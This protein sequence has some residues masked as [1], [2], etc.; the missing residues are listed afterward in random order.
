VNEALKTKL[1]TLPASPGVYFHKSAGGEVIYVGK[2]AVL[3]NRVRQYFQAARNLDAKT[4]ALVAEIDDTDWLET[5]SEIDALFLESEMVKRYMPRYNVLLRDDKSQ[6][7]VRIDMKSEWPTVSFTR[8]PQDDGADYYGPF[9]NG[10]ALKKALRYLRRVFPYFIREPK[11]TDSKLEQQIGLNP[12]M[13][14]GSDAYKATLRKL[15]SYIKGNRKAIAREIEADMKQAAREHDFETAARLRN[16]LWNMREL[17]RRVMFGDR[18]FL[19]ISK[20][21]ALGDLADVLGLGD[22]PKRIEGYD[23]SH[24]SGKDV[25]A[26]MVVFT[27]GVSDRAEYRKF[28]VK[29]TNDDYANIYE[30]VY[31]RLSVNNLQQWGKP[32]LMLIDGGKGQLDAALKAM[33]ARDQHFPCISIAKREEELIIHREKSGVGVD[34]LEV[35]IK[36]GES[37]IEAHMSGSYFVVNL[38][39]G[40]RNAGSH[41]KNLRAGGYRTGYTDIVKLIQRIRDESHRFAVSY[42]T[43]LGRKKAT[44]SA[45]EELPGV[46]PATRK[47]LLRHFG[48]LRMVT[49]ATP[50]QLAEVVSKKQATTIAAW[51]GTIKA[52]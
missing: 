10:Y 8:N 28:K 34:S 18:E 33:A 29:E 4:M 42:H 11:S 35:A 43:A 37:K 15:I 47:K 36:A 23:I 20:D 16:R 41:S 9:Y 39:P 46:G 40:Q 1:K 5:E 22:A 50:D 27:N 48:S 17:Q 14:L 31:R 51:S 19:D 45:L 6:S 38:H 2:A 7:F 25:V 24:I 52:K 44:A 13:G 49:Q 12:D 21:K 3:K 26:S 30:T 32:N